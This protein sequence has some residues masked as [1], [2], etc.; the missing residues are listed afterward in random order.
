MDPDSLRVT[1]ALGLATELAE[2]LVVALLPD[3]AALPDAAVVADTPVEVAELDVFED[4]PQA[5]IA[6]GS[7]TARGIKRFK[8]ILSRVR[9]T[10]VHERGLRKEV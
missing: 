3:V 5:P 2:P 4:E 10:S 8:G 6:I 1:V 9:H 7:A